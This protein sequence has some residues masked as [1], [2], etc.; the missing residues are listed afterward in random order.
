[1]KNENDVGGEFIDNT[2]AYIQKNRMQTFFALVLLLIILIQ[3]PLIIA[4]L[5]NTTV[6]VDLPPS[7]KLVL[8]NDSANKQYYNLWAEHFTN[9]TEYLTTNKDGEKVPEAFTFSIVNFDYTNIDKKMEYFL[10]Y[11]KPSKLIK[12]RMKF[13]KFI[14]NIKIKMI[15]HDFKVENIN[16]ELYLEGKKAISTI[17]GVSYQKIGVSQ[18]DPKACNFEMS[19]ERIGGN[20]YVTSLRTNCF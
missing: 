20:I 4:E 3:T 19:F 18:Q 17:N 15:S 7:G 6:V 1:M 9:N 10:S 5:D 2:I 8:K 12:D 11:Y 16:T 14:K 13:Q